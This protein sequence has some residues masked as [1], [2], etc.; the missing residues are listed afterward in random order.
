LID[1][2]LRSVVKLP[3]VE[4]RGTPTLAK[5]IR[6][7]TMTD[8]EIS[9]VKAMLSKGIRNDAIHFYFNRAD[10]LLSSGRIAQIRKKK[11]GASVV[12]ASPDELELFLA[13]WHARQA[14]GDGQG[15]ISPV[16]PGIITAMFIERAGPTCLNRLSASISG[17]SAEIRPPRGAAEG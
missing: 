2:H 9:L 12:E 16:A 5:S 8:K 15:A 17:A 10:R 7:R 4:Y 3:D 6:K 11:Y 13:D 1:V 14:T